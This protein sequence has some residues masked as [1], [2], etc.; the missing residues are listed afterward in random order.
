MNKRTKLFLIIGGVILLAGLVV[1]G[2]GM[3]GRLPWQQGDLYA[4][5]QGRFTV[6]L[7][8]GW[9]QVE[10]EGPYMQFQLADPP[11][12]LY[13]LVLESS[14]V[15]EAFYQAADVVRFDPGLLSGGAVAR[16][17]DWQVYSKEDDAGLQYGL[18]GQLIGQHAYVMVAKAD[19][20]GVSIENPAVLRAMISLKIASKEEIVIESYADLESFVQKQVNSQ[21]GSISVAVLHSDE[22]VY[23]YVYGEANPV[24]GIPAD[25]ET[26]YRFGSMTKPVTAT[27]LMQL[28]EQGK[29]DLDAWAGRYV[30]E[31]PEGWKVSVRQLLDH[32]ACM[33]DSS[34]LTD[35]L[36]AKPGESFAPLEEIFAKYVKD[37]PDL[38]C[39]PG[40][41]SQYANPHYLAL[42]R[43][44]EEVSGEPYETYVIEHVL[45]PLKMDSTRFQV[46][47]ADERYAKG[48]WPADKTDEL[49]AQL[50]EYRGPGQE[51]LILRYGEGYST[52]DDF[53]VLAPWGG[54]FGTPI[55]VTHFL[56]MYL[57]DG[58][59]WNVQILQPETVAAMEEMQLS[60]DGSPLGFGLSWMPAED[61]YGK[62]YWHS[63]G[64]HTIESVMR[65]YPDLDLGVVVMSNFN[66]SLAE[67]I[68]EGLVSAWTH[69]E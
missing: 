56:Q 20:P 12:K 69:E 35:A 19:Q 11:L 32:S 55:D 4:D 50:N 26:I 14:T 3:L 37:Y 49:V 63:G 64:G 40:K 31:F 45:I 30:P 9:E 18:A 41:V 39:E 27:A 34:R 60:T 24:D 58:R 25:T 51:D 10:A 36:I 21:T 8:S 46:V 53:R 43:I 67:K 62:F 47:E 29:V 44:I 42:A 38:G 16:I 2:L 65:Y 23:T 15:D 13:L 5:P 66:G 7:G 57:N 1:G 22:I 68:A 28:V 61:N 54:L 6:E 17:E 33:Q 59:Y 52:M 48:Q